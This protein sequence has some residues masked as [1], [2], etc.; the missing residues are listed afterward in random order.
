[1]GPHVS[2]NGERMFFRSLQV[3]LEG[4]LGPQPPLRDGQGNPRDPQMFFRASKDF[5]HSWSNQQIA[6]CGSA[7]EFSKRVI[8]SRLGSAFDWVPEISM[9]DPVPWRIID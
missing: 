9:T 8:F 2:N 6:D 7:G 3:L 1:R 5:G 4:G